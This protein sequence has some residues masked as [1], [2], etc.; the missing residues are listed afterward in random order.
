MGDSLVVLGPGDPMR[1]VWLPIIFSDQL[2]LQCTM[3]TTSVHMSAVYGM[4]LM[5]NIDVVTH[6]AGALALL[7]QRLADSLQAV[8]DITL[9]S[10]LGFLGQVVRNRC[11]V[12]TVTTKT[13]I[14][15]VYEHPRNN[16]AS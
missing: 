10:V 6:R 13:F 9:T 5:F 2:L 7:N 4:D 8:T 14:D 11:M 3:Y 12:E 15:C 1:D 16:I